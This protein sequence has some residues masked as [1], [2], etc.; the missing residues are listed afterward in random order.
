MT[1]QSRLTGNIKSPMTPGWSVGGLLL[2][3]LAERDF[4]RMSE[5]FEPAATM[6]ALLPP[7]LTE[8]KGA[9]E[10]VESLRSWFGGAHEFEVLDGTVSEVGGRLHIAWRLRL[11][12]TPWG[13]DAWHVIE[14]H[15]YV[16]AGERV[17]AMDLLCSGFHPDDR[18]SAAE[19]LER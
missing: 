11:R 4:V 3:A 1:D 19:R 2:E 9:G 15:V 18:R 8:R 16:Q 7:G 10:I 14:Q 12:P 13:D 6:R 5:C 17:E